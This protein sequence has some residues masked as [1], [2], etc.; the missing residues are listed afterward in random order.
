MHQSCVGEL[1]LSHIAKYTSTCGHIVYCTEF[2]VSIYT[3]IVV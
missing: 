2:I 3:D 1:C